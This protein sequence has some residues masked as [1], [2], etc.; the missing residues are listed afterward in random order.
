MIPALKEQRGYLDTPVIPTQLCSYRFVLCSCPH[1][2]PHLACLRS[3]CS[4]KS[5]FPFCFF[6]SYVCSEL[7]FLFPILS[8]HTFFCFYSSPCHYKLGPL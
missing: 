7:C 3:S 8:T 2:Y 6:I 1:A 4:N 5:C